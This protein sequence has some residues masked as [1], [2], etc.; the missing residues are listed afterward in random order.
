MSSLGTG[1]LTTGGDDA[2][3]TFSGVISGT[4]ALVKFVT[5]TMTLTGASTL[6]GA[7]TLNGGTLALSGAAGTATS[8]SGF[9]LNTGTTLTLDNSGGENTNRIGNSAPI[10]LSGGTLRFISDANGSTE[11]VG[12]LNPSGGA[13]SIVIV[14]NGLATDNTVANVQLARHHC[15][16]RER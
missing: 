11:T 4:G 14:H 12:A 10:N 7:V 6:S 2:T 13:S 9:T 15:S 3:T 16:R 1:T 8:V 5:G